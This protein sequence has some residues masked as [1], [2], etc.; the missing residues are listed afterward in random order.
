MGQA[1]QLRTAVRFSVGLDVSVVFFRLAVL[2]FL[3]GTTIAVA[4]VSNLR[5]Q[6]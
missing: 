4:L 2:C 5:K 1:D 3:V 6:S